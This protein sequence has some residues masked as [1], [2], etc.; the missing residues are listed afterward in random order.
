MEASYRFLFTPRPYLP[1]LIDPPP[2]LLQFFEGQRFP[3][4]KA[5][6][7]NFHTRTAPCLLKVD[8]I[9]LPR[10]EVDAFT[11]AVFEFAWREVVIVFLGRSRLD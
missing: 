1:A 11:V 6:P 5:S 2:Q 4:T 9:D 10:I 7:A 3:G 8:S